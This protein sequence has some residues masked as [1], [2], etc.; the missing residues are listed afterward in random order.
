MRILL[1]DLLHGAPAV[2]KF[3]KQVLGATPNHTE[4]IRENKF[5]IGIVRK[6]IKAHTRDPLRTIR[7]SPVTFEN[8][9]FDLVAIRKSLHLKQDDVAG[10]LGIP[11]PKYSAWERGAAVPTPYQFLILLEILGLDFLK[12][13]N[14][15]LTDLLN[16]YGHYTASHF[17]AV[18]TGSTESEDYVSVQWAMMVYGWRWHFGVPMTILSARL[19]SGASRT[20]L[21]NINGLSAAS[22][23]R[24]E[25]SVKCKMNCER[26][27]AISIAYNVSPLSLLNGM[28]MTYPAL[29][30]R[31]FIGAGEI[32]HFDIG[33][34]VIAQEFYNEV[35]FSKM[36][37]ICIDLGL[38]P[39]WQI[40]LF[41]ML[42]LTEIS[43]KT[44]LDNGLV[45]YRP[46]PLTPDGLAS[47]LGDEQ[48]APIAE[49][50]E[51]PDS[52]ND[53]IIRDSPTHQAL[54]HIEADHTFRCEVY[55]NV[56]FWR[57]DMLRVYGLEHNHA[58]I[59]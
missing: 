40:P 58:E 11:Q 43:D 27:L 38:I 56:A 10:K 28:L 42:T 17:A 50:L 18:A 1:N 9:Q 22:L 33:G 57:V 34:E 46:F 5:L 26:F 6:L 47:Y 25:N 45:E 15:I 37:K 36:K 41:E 59:A 53:L 29:G 44:D 52:F 3:T 19:L 12:V 39:G 23:L 13:G 51:V 31:H 54:D 49:T 14:M 16:G 32:K 35:E 2:T 8:C 7:H 55:Y 30:L 24:L 21:N 20:L 4:F 48:T